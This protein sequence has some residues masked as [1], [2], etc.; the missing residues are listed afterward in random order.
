MGSLAVGMEVYQSQS[1]SVRCFKCLTQLKKKWFVRNFFD[2]E[3]PSAFS[4]SKG[5]GSCYLF[6]RILPSEPPLHELNWRLVAEAGMLPFP[7]VEHFDVLKAGGAYTPR[8][9]KFP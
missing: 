1:A 9:N 4:S 3:L 7:V 8:V 6:F 5:L 2:G